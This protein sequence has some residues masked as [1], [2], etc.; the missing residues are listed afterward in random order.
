MVKIWLTELF[1]KEIENAKVSMSNNRL[2]AI[3]S[4][5]KE[6]ADM[7]IENIA[8]LE[9]YVQILSSLIKQV[10]EETLNV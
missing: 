1:Q 5:T 3:G 7:F 2:W 9:E 10:E 4:N 6:E 8:S